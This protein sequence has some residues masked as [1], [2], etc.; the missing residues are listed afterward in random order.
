MITMNTV[1]IRVIKS[2]DRSWIL[3]LLRSEWGSEMVVSRGNVHNAAKLHGFIAC[4]SGKPCGLLTYRLSG[5]QCEIV[6][7]NSLEQGRGI[8]SALINS[9]IETARRK[10]CRRIWL[11][12][13]N[14]NTDALRFYQKRGFQMVAIHRDALRYSRRLKPEIPLI[15]RNGIPL[16]DEIELEI[17]F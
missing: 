8:G 13:T 2:S 5:N 11:I 17:K 4:L 15:G 7:L 3:A 1:K 6:T 12:T 10:N 9:A 14:D 16:R